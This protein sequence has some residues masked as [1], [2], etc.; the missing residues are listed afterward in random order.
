MVNINIKLLDKSINIPKYA[1]GGDAGLDLYSRID[2]ILKP[3]ARSKIPTGIQ[4][5]IP[6]GY[7][8]FVQPKSGLAIKNGI[9]LVNSPGLIDSGFRGEI[10]AILINLDKE[11]EFKINKGDKICQLVIQK[12]EKAGISIVKELD[13]TSRGEGGFG[14]TGKY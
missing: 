10:C 1:H 6:S 4:I 12:V 14:S 9:A 2:L 7:A 8:G 11:K 3:F 13:A 5:A